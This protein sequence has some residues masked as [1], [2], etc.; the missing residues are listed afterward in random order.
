MSAPTSGSAGGSP[1]PGFYPDPSIPGYIRYW[2]GAAWVPGT[3]RPAPADGEAMP[4][5]PPGVAPSPE[6]SA[7]LEQGGPPSAVEETGPV[8]FD[9]E[10]AAGGSAVPAVRQSGDVAPASW[11]DPARLHGTSPESAA[12]WQADASRQAGFGGEP[13][14]RISWGS[15][16]QAPPGTPAG[17]ASWGAVPPQREGQGAEAAAG[18][19]PGAAAQGPGVPSDGT[20]TIRAVNPAARRGGNSGDQGT[21]AIRAVRPEGGKPAKG[22]E[23]MAIRVAGGGRAPSAVPGD[24]SPQSLP[25]G[26]DQPQNRPAAQTP[27]Q[28]SPAPQTPAQQSPAPQRPTPQNPAPQNPAPQAPVQ[29]QPAPQT[30]APA[31]GVPPQG[32]AAAARPGP[33]GADADGVIPWKPPAAADPFAALA[34]AAQGHPAALGRRFAA[35]LIDTLVLGALTAAVAVPMWGTVADHLDAKVEAAKQSGRQVTV[36]LVDGTTMPV[37]ATILAVLL[38]G[39]ALYEALPT[40]KWGRTLGKKLCGVRV[41]DIESHDT[42]TLGAA[43]KRWFLYSVLGV[44]V[45]G[46]LNVVWCLFDRP[47][48]QCWHDKLARTFVAAG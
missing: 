3:S 36:Y 2:N 32:G 26:N 4:A 48:R 16:D 17:A 6:F 13:D 47:W 25:T 40:L 31:A 30:A 24:A 12:A 23:T 27:A 14:R 5:P 44:L 10:E 21:T 7:P 35:R 20:V 46:V 22:N 38:I 34:E 39:G 8:F 43:L 11:D 37:F 19:V 45:I 41:L 9:E 15:P 18:E 33:Q 28:Q 29:Q 1:T 42:P